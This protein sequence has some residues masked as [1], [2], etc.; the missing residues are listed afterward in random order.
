M[1]LTLVVLAFVYMR[2]VLTVRLNYGTIMVQQL[3]QWRTI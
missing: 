3:I 1:R 2:L